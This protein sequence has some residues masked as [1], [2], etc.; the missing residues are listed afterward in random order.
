M[1][2]APGFYAWWTRPACLSEAVPAIPLVC[3]SGSPA[4]WALLYV[5][6][7]PRG[8]RSRAAV[9]R[10]IAARISKDHRSGN[11][12]GST[13]RQS[14]ASLLR[15]SLALLPK[16][17]HDRARLVTEA[18]LSLW[19]SA[20]C[21]LTTAVTA[22]PSRIEDEVIRTLCAPLNLRPGYHEFRFAVEQARRALRH[23]CGLLAPLLAQ[24]DEEATVTYAAPLE[25]AFGPA[26]GAPAVHAL[27]QSL[28]QPDAVA[29][30]ARLASEELGLD[31]ERD[32]DVI[33]VNTNARGDAR[34]MLLQVVALCEKAPL[35]VIASDREGQEAVAVWSAPEL[36]LITEH[37]AGLRGAL[38]ELRGFGPGTYVDDLQGLPRPREQW[39][40][41]SPIPERARAL[42]HRF[43]LGARF[44]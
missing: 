16:Q 22:T 21:A 4:G 28:L 1:P 44:A 30:A 7:A 40:G 2:E 35:A 3:P 41:S 32:G 18:P 33:V 5:G 34:R 37:A 31:L 27:V 10:T 14:L 19:I 29:D 11:I 13:F 23:N 26:V 36:V 24:T 6:I 9:E 42:L 17:G 38:Y 15:G 8:T 39:A 25:R 43:H 12:G 20:H